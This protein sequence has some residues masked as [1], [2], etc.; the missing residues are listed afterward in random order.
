M[1]FFFQFIDGTPA[2][3]VHQC[4]NVN[5]ELFIDDEHFI[6]I[7]IEVIKIVRSKSKGKSKTLH[8]RLAKTYDC[9]QWKL[10]ENDLREYWSK[11]INTS[12]PSTIY[13]WNMFHQ[14]IEKYYNVLLG[15]ALMLIH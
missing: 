12:I 9:L 2:K 13:S 15:T 8:E 11:Y 10:N 5:H 3:N 1:Y 7:L 6:P 14:A 4:E